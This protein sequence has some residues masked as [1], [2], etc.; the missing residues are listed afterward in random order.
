M[1]ATG[2]VKGTSKKLTAMLGTNAWIITS[3]LEDPEKAKYLAI[4]TGVYL[5][6]QGAQDC[7]KAWKGRNASTGSNAEEPL[8]SVD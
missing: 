8:V 1:T 7:I 6:A 5:L 3:S 2:I 4:V